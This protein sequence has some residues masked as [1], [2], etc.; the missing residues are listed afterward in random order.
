MNVYEFAMQMEKDGEACYR[1]IARKTKNAGLQKIFKTL[2]DEEVVHF[3]T[4]KKHMIK[5]QLKLSRG[6]FSIRQ[7]I[8][9]LI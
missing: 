1:E 4:F 6:I 8:Y 3:N 5:I 2:A 9:L 7:R